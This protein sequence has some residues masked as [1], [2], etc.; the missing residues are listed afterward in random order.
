MSIFDFFRSQPQPQPTPKP[1]TVWAPGQAGCIDP[2]LDRLV[3]WKGF[4]DHRYS[5]VVGEWT[6]PEDPSDKRPVFCDLATAPHILVAGATGSGKSVAINAML[7]SLLL[8]C[9][10]NHLTLYMID[11][12][13]VELARYSGIPHLGAPI[14]TDLD[15]AERVLC[16]VRKEMEARFQRME[17]IGALHI[18]ELGMGHVL[19]VMDEFASLMSKEGKKRLLPHL[20]EIARLGRAAGVHMILATQRPTRDVLDGQLKSNCP[21]RLAFRVLSVTDSRVILDAKGAECLKGAGDGLIRTAQG[22]LWRFQG[23]YCSDQQVKYLC[24]YWRAQ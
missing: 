22:D 21:T 24:D 5:V 14:A 18:D 15:S 4:T 2:D 6:N 13:R 10:P 7:C 17:L 8:K 23:C 20:Q 9:C 19:L 3:R 1:R 11:P 16:A 12:K